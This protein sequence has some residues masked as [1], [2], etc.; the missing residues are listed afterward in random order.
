MPHKLRPQPSGSNLNPSMG[1]ARAMPGAH[2]LSPVGGRGCTGAASSPGGASPRAMVAHFVTSQGAGRW[3]RIT[4]EIVASPASSPSCHAWSTDKTTAWAATR[5]RPL[6]R[7]IHPRQEFLPST[8]LRLH[9]HYR[10]IAGFSRK[11]FLQE[12]FPLKCSNC[13]IAPTICVHSR[14]MK[15]STPSSWRMP[16][17]EMYC[18]CT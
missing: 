2:R 1:G 4:E 16:K 18:A 10:N 13:R 14:G 17:G 5:G 15:K 11:Y 3:R 12:T 6:G 9:S 8:L 7:R